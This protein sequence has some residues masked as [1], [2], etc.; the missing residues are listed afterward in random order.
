MEK[1]TVTKKPSLKLRKMKIIFPS[2][3]ELDKKHILVFFFN[4]NSSIGDGVMDNFS[5]TIAISNLAPGEKQGK[6]LLS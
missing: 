4:T 5:L 1:S 6:F 2:W 3:Q